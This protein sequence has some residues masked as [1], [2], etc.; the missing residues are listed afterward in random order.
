MRVS[1]PQTKLDKRT[2]RVAADKISPDIYVH[3]EEKR[4]VHQEKKRKKTVIKLTWEYEI[5]FLSFLLKEEKKTDRQTLTTMLLR[6]FESN[7]AYCDKERKKR[8]DP[9]T[10]ETK[11]SRDLAPGNQFIRKWL[12]ALWGLECMWST[13]TNVRWILVVCP[14]WRHVKW[15]LHHLKFENFVWSWGHPI[16]SHPG[17]NLVC[18]TSK[19]WNIYCDCDCLRWNYYPVSCFYLIQ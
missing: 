16:P 6:C 8:K 2:S 10:K 4:K 5:F 13:R 9:D 12:I 17:V 1:H 7:V 14:F 11:S 3:K 18:E 15:G 19:Q